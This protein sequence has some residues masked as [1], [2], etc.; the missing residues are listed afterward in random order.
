MLSSTEVSLIQI[1]I[2]NSKSWL[3]GY[4][5]NRIIRTIRVCFDHK[6]SGVSNLIGIELL[7][8]CVSVYLLA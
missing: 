8:L 1:T 4:H 3:S 5:S 6:E 7:K 2:S